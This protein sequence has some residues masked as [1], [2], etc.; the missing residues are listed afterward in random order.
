[1]GRFNPFQTGGGGVFGAFKGVLEMS[2]RRNAAVLLCV[3]A[4]CK[5]ILCPR[6]IL[7]ST[8]EDILYY[9]G[10]EQEAVET[11]HIVV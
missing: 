3:F 10:N 6:D 2:M 4:S 8:Y 7:V 9:G 11:I 5:I 1:M